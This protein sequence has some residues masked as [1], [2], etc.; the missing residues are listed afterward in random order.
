MSTGS[1]AE[2]LVR[3]LRGLAD[4]STFAMR[5]SVCGLLKGF[6]GEPGGKANKMHVDA[7]TKPASKAL[8]SVPLNRKLSSARKGW[9]RRCSRYPAR[10]ELKFARLGKP[11]AAI[12]REALER[13]GTPDMVMLGDQPE[14]DI[15]GAVEFGLDAVLVG[16]G[17]ANMKLKAVN[18]SLQP[19]YF[20]DSLSL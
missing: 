7:R 12:F 16:T 6:S 15:R 4:T 11:H 14:T 17:I 9:K 3:E 1:P 10:P 18:K 19:T 20:L 5:S 2:P 13:S 8:C